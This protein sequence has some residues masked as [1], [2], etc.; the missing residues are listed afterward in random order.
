MCQ[1]LAWQRES[2]PR[3]E[4]RQLPGKHFFIFGSEQEIIQMITERLSGALHPT[5]NNFLFS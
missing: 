3:I 4:V 1:V 5:S 2:I